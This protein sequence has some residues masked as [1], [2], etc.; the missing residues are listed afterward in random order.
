MSSGKSI[1]LSIIE[2]TGD[3]GDKYF[4]TGPLYAAISTDR[5]RRGLSHSCTA[6]SHLLF[7]LLF[8]TPTA[9]TVD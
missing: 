6:Q 8:P 5:F 2:R 9:V 3:S 1:A 4:Q 7:Q